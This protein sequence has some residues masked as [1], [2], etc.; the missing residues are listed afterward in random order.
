MSHVRTGLIGWP[1]THSLSP[2][3][4]AHWIKEHQLDATYDLFPVEASE[5][6]EVAQKMRTENIRGMN[7]TVPHK[8]RIVYHIDAMDGLA[9]KIGAINTIIQR[10]GRLYGMNTDAYGFITNLKQ[11]LG[12]L[13]PY[14]ARVVLL[15]AGGAARAIVVALQEAGAKNIVITNRTAETAEQVANDFAIEIAPWE[16]RDRIFGE[17]SLLINATSLGMQGKPALNIDLSTLPKAAA[18]HDIV[19]APLETDLLRE[20]KARGNRTVDGLGMLI[21]QAQRA[22]EQ[23]HGILPEVTPELRKKVLAP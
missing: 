20:A 19:Y 7:V 13:E 22:F 21:Y 10:N 3:I 11:G 14:L 16:E 2:R 18:V 6:G 9:K 12:K 4:H 23:W 8:E 1:L 5:L 17:T 15:G